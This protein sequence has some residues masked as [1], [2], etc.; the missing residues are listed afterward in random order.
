MGL[1]ITRAIGR[2][3][4]TEKSGRRPPRAIVDPR[5]ALHEL[6]L[7]KRPEEL[8]A[9][10]KA[11]EIS[12]EAHVLAMRTGKPGVF[13]HELEALINYTFR[14]HGGAGPG[15]ATIVGAGENAT[16]L[17]YI[18]NKCAIGNGDLVLV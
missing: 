7:H 10:R 8:Q 6:R 4:K 9:L 12:S 11:A 17:H 16:I 15:Y 3:R 5:A 1:W 2:L 13:E 14:R 18:D